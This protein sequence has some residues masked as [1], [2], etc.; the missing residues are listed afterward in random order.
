MS[1]GET[2][3][4]AAAPS[5]IVA[6]LQLLAAL[7]YDEGCALCVARAVL[8]DE[9]LSDCRHRSDIYLFS[10]TSIDEDMVRVYR[11]V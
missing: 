1:C 3:P 11:S 2:E 8:F 10:T 9:L 6:I 5:S 4:A 7:P